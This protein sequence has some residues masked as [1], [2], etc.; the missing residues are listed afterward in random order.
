MVNENLQTSE[1]NIFAIGEAAS[2][3][4]MVYGLVAPGYEM[5][6]QVVNQ[7]MGREIKPFRGFDMSTKLKLIGVE[8]GSFGDPF[9]ESEP[10][11]PIIY[12]NKSSGIYKRINISPDG[13]D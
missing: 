9:G 3:D 2:Y 8:V 5:A 4:N 10:S 13:K 12:E 7:L 6:T 1:P 11:K